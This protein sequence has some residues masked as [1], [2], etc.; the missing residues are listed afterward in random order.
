MLVDP[1]S[2]PVLDTARH[3][4]VSFFLRGVAV[5]FQRLKAVDTQL[6]LALLAALPVWV[7][8]A[9]WAQPGM[10]V[11][12]GAWAWCS[13]VLVQP[14]LEEWVF[15]GL[16]QG[17]AL[18]L[19]SRQGV[20]ARLGPVTWANVLVTL[21]FVALHLMAQPVVW[22]VAVAIPSL[23][24]GHLRERFNS[25]W[26]PVWVHAFYNAGFGL[27]AWAAVSA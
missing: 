6:M 17:Q 20:P 4:A 7:A 11:P 23:V 13:L 21:A 12:Q 18:R 1:R 22:A 14:C 8:L 26:P 9:V 10:R 27:T 24:L 2:L 3:R 25:V 5:P 19:T 15:R 16:L